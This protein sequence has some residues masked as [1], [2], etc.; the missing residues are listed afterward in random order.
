MLLMHA[1]IFYLWYTQYRAMFNSETCL[2][3]Q[4]S[5]S[6]YF[7]KAYCILILDV[8][9]RDWFGNSTCNIYNAYMCRRTLF[10]VYCKTVFASLGNVINLHGLWKPTYIFPRHGRERACSTNTM[11]VPANN[12][13]MT[14]MNILHTLVEA[15]II[16]A[17]SNTETITMMQEVTF[18]VIRCI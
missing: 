16:D 13:V 11:S 6:H 10:Q 8:A 4:R 2:L 9:C 18:P 15:F 14:T 17:W 12:P 1:Y 3:V 5:C 7:N